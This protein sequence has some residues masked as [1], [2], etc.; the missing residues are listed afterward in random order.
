MAVADSVYSQSVIS[1][2]RPRLQTR[3]LW[4]ARRR[5]RDWEGAAPGATQLTWLDS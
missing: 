4:G 5:A 3:R 1:R 2:S